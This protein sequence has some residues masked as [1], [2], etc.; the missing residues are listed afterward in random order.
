MNEKYNKTFSIS[1]IHMKLSCD[2]PG[3]ITIYNNI[4]SISEQIFSEYASNLGIQYTIIVSRTHIHSTSLTSFPLDFVDYTFP[5]YFYL[6]NVFCENNRPFLN[7][8]KSDDGR[9]IKLIN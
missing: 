1:L 5:S 4:L 2:L 9:K 3:F 7:K 8:L 6:I